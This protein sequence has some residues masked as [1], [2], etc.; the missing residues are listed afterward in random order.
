MSIPKILH[1]TISN[2]ECLHSLVKENIREI[3]I[4]NRDWEYRL[5]DDEDRCTFIRKYYGTSFLNLYE[6]IDPAYGAARADFFRYL[7]IYEH[8]GVYLDIKSSVKKRL[9]EVLTEK[10]TYILSHWQSCSDERYKGWGSHPEFGIENE[11]QQWHIIAEPKHPFLKSVID[12]VTHNLENYDASRDGVGQLG[13]LALT[14]PIAYTRAIIPMLHYCEHRIVNIY[15]LG[16]EYSIF[17]TENN[18]TDHIR[19]YP[20]HYTKLT[21]PIVKET[22]NK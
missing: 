14:G 11:F 3:S 4:I 2:K 19:I 16:F 8:G 15:S 18:E 1:Q 10:E 9:N 20:Q 12:V 21:I 17:A 13:V 7:L 6:K 22:P 5:Y